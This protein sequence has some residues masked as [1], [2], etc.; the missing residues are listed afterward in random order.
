[1]PP[2]RIIVGFERNLSKE[3]TT[4][5]KEGIMLRK[6]PPFFPVLRENSAQ[7]GLPAP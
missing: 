5:E 4:L 6:E 3:A 2:Y 7:T 1:M